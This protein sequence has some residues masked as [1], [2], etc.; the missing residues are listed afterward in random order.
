MTSSILENKPSSYVAAEVREL[1]QR[2]YRH[3]LNDNQNLF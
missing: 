3:I 1:I 2:M